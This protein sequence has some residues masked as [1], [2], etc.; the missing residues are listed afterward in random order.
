[1]LREEIYWMGFWERG[2]FD[3]DKVG[4]RTV[5][6]NCQVTERKLRQEI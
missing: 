1:M 5:V 2:G 4:W 3:F 6:S